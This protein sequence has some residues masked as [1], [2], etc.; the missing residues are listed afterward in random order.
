MGVMEG[1]GF[2]PL[3]VERPGSRA[4]PSPRRAPSSRRCQF[5]E[6]ACDL[7]LKR[8]RHYRKEWDDDHGVWKDRPRHDDSSHGADAFLTFACSDYE[9]PRPY[10]HVEA[11]LSWVV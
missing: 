2:R 6:A 7:G 11:D 5:D 9:P 3:V 10:K 1:L 8:L 4:R